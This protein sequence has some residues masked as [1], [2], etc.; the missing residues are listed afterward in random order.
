MPSRYTN[1]AGN[2]SIELNNREKGQKNGYILYF[3]FSFFPVDRATRKSMKAN[4]K[5]FTFLHMQSNFVMQQER[6]KTINNKNIVHQLQWINESIA[7]RSRLFRVVCELR[8]D[9]ISVNI[10]R[11]NGS[12]KVKDT[13]NHVRPIYCF[14]DANSNLSVVDLETCITLRFRLSIQS[15]WHTR[16]SFVIAITVLV[17]FCLVENIDLS[18]M[19]FW[20]K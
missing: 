16:L 9:I 17:H 2:I 19:N 18:T 1:T 3:P 15:K 12:V 8:G 14:E 6:V 7:F 4:D 11:H 10:G 5:F 13:N 20:G